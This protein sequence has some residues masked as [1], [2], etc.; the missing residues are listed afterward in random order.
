MS[1][2]ARR[3]VAGASIVLAAVAAAIAAAMAWEFVISP[4]N[5]QTL[6]SA[7]VIQSSSGDAIFV[8]LVAA[9]LSA[10][11]IASVVAS[12]SDRLR[13]GVRVAAAGVMTIAG[14][15][16]ALLLDPAS[17]S[18]QAR[19]MVYPHSEGGTVTVRL[20]TP[21]IERLS[22]LSWLYAAC[23]AGMALTAVVAIA[24][25]RGTSHRHQSRPAVTPVG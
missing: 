23:G 12:W 25:N 22:T 10:L 6:S 17:A 8:A 11:V 15:A 1:D 14:C 7:S 4:L 9:G 21:W 24:L 13:H 18:L 19:F 16:S 3:V 2:P 5:D 20:F